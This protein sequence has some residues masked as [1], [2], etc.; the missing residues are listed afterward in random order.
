MTNLWDVTL[1]MYCAGKSVS[2]IVK[3][4]GL[5][6]DTIYNHLMRFVDSGELDAH[7]FVSGEIIREVRVFKANNP[8]CERLKEIFDGLGGKVSYSEIRFALKCL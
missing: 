8:E 7:E 2:E 1:E 5:T 3:E 6:Q 4:R